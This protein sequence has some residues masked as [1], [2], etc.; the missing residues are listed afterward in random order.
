MTS[1]RWN[2]GTGAPRV[3]VGAMM[4]VPKVAVDMD[5]LRAELTIK[6]DVFWQ[7]L[8]VGGKAEKVDPVYKLWTE[9]ED[10]VSVPRHYVEQR[11]R[12]ARLFLHP[13]T[14]HVPWRPSSPR[15]RPL[16]HSIKLRN[17]TQR[18]A[19][20]ALR[21]DDNDKIISLACGKG[22]TVVSLHAASEGKRFPL[23]I[24]VH[25]NQLADQ[26]RENYDDDGNLVGGIKKFYGL[27]DDEIGHIQ[28]KRCDWRGKKVA[29][30]MLH[31]LVLKEFDFDFY[32]YWRCVIFDEVHRLGAY[33]FQKAASMFPG[34]RW[35]LSATVEREDLMDRVFR[36]HLGDVVY[37]DLEQE[38]KPEIFFIDTGITADMTRFTMRSGRT[39][40]SKLQTHLSEHDGRNE[41]IRAWLRKAYA[42][43]RTII[44]LGERLSQLHEMAETFQDEGVDAAV[45]VGST[46][47]AQ[48]RE[49]LRRRMIF[50]TQHIARE[51]LDKVS[52]DT[53][54]ILI[55]F[56]GKGR[57]QQ[58]LGRMLRPKEG[59]LPPIAL[60]FE[61]RIGIV[62]ALGRKMRRFIRAMGYEPQEISKK[63]A[64]AEIAKW[65][66][67][68]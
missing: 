21:K 24:V 49:A 10:M 67:V 12:A 16:H 22:K 53:L 5:V 55:P 37:E 19:S 34:E 44:T 23:L 25:T 50:A 68:K 43:K 63:T 2:P 58:S 30:A 46:K 38:L 4:H 28:G 6:N 54:F 27:Q 62:G 39:N 7:T 48:R 45:F 41:L 31:T 42:R 57:L 14:E 17:L 35:G 18:R 9:T 60:I 1:I 13:I 32:R 20:E 3:V 40:L 26:W 59:K 8:S 52:L 51:G 56:G 29:I 64:Y 11:R 65:R 33:F 66:V 61:D 47:K 36:I 15:V